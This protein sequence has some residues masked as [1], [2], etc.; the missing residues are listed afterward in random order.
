MSRSTFLEIT[1]LIVALAP[2]ASAVAQDS[3]P[4][5][6]DDEAI[7][8]IVFPENVTAVEQDADSATPEEGSTGVEQPV[9]DTTPGLADG[10]GDNMDAGSDE[11]GEVSDFRNED[12]DYGYEEP[13]S[14]YA[15]EEE[16]DKAELVQSFELYKSSIENGMY[17]EADTLAKRIIE[18]SIKLYGI[19]SRDS[20]KALTNLG[21]V[22]YHNK[23]FD[24]AQLNYQAAIDIIE[25]I[26]DRL[27]AD[28]INPLKGLGAA[29]LAAGRPDL[30]KD[31]FDRAV[32]VS[33]VNEGPHNLQQV[34]MLDAL[35]ETYLT[36]G[37][38]DEALDVQEKVVNLQ[39]RNV[40]L[41]SEAAIPALEREALWMHRMQRYNA[42][43]NSYRKIIRIL[44]KTRGSDDIALIP[45]LTGLGKSYLFVEPYDPEMQ[46]YTPASGGEVYLKRALRI[47][48]E[49]PQ[50]DWE[51][52]RGSMLAL[53]DFYTL[54]GRESRATRAYTEV[55][56]FLSADEER[57]PSRARDLESSVVFQDISPTLYY[58]SARQDYAATPPENFERGTIVVGYAID[59]SGQAGNIRLIEAR[60]PGL[61]EMQHEV[62]REVRDLIHRPRLENGSVVPVDDLTYT[63]E[64]FYRPSDLTVLPAES[65]L[66]GS[67]P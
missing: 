7:Q 53:G 22:Q 36:V 4:D 54:S 39:L 2:V 26:E 3:P 11:S 32:H 23:D 62:M 35:T 51:I 46:S 45:P 6:K 34:D 28:L 5:A 61:V 58:N 29:Q 38:V 18:L 42:E 12:L 1:F 27:H 20:A 30:A 33:H 66:A 65:E 49:S 44:E 56:E 8:A 40:D 15:S 59:T 31:T 60:P 43:R 50:S 16:R 63:H 21:T 47:A 9:E 52:L 67:S 48:E 64:F 24:S 10:S 37:E 17:E 57:I 41:E 13:V 55:W 25:R 14:E 19:N